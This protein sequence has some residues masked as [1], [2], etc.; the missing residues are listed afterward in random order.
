MKNFDDNSSLELPNLEKLLSPINAEKPCGEYLKRSSIIIQLKELRTKLVSIDDE[1]RGIW[2]KKQKEEHDW[3]EV[4]NLAFDI[5]STHTKDLNVVCTLMEA[6]FKME[7]FVGLAKALSLFC[8]FC[9][10]YWENIN[11]PVIEENY[12]LRAAAFKALR[13]NL[14]LLIKSYSFSVV[15]EQEQDV[16]T[17][18]WYESQLNIGKTEGIQAKN[19]IVSAVESKSNSAI[20]SLNKALEFSLA[21]LNFL[22]DKYIPLL[23]LDEDDHVTFEDLI[24]LLQQLLVV[25]NKIYSDRIHSNVITNESK[26][27]N[28][29]LELNTSEHIEG[30]SMDF[31]NSNSVNTIQEAY[32]AIAKANEFLLK[33]DPHSPSPYLIRRALDWR[34]KSLYS[35]FIELFSST[36]KPQEI[37]SLL[38]LSHLD[39]NKK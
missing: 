22:E 36:S 7:G 10:V 11:P 3:G 9:E 35:V 34:K 26:Y 16:L 21:K 6:K 33:N 23:I 2:V 39:K 24:N 27:D 38:G 15:Q 20:I 19:K 17:W 29:Q 1:N 37:F 12:E 4:A 30:I 18:A 32:D 8:Q 14:L 25:V 5:L 31:L 13:N 28:K